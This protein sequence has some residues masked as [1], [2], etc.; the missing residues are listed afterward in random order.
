MFNQL[1]SRPKKN[2]KEN[3]SAVTLRSGK[4]YDPPIILKPKIV[5]P[6]PQDDNPGDEIEAPK[7]N[8]LVPPKPTFSTPPPFPRRL[9]KTKKEE[10]D[11][12]ILETFC[13]VE[14]NIP[15]LDAI[16]KVP[17]YAKSN[18]YPR[19]V[20]EDVLVQVN[21][22]VFP[23][24]FYVLNME[25]DSILCSTPILL[26]RPFMKTARAKID[27]HKGTL[28]M[29][30]DGKTIR[31]NIFSAMSEKFSN[32]MVD[33]IT[34]LNNDFNK[35]YKKVAY[36]EL[37][38]LTDK[39]QPSIVQ[40][41][42]IELKTMPNHLKYAYLGE[43]ETLPVMIAKELD[44]V[45]EEKFIRVLRAHRTAITWSITNIKGISPTTCIRIL[46]K[47]GAKPTRDAQRRLNP[48][49][50]EVVNK[51]ILK[52]FGV[53]IIYP[54]SYSKWVSH[55]QVVPKIFGI[56]IVKNEDNELVPTRMQ[57]GWQVCIDYRKLNAATRKDHFTLPFID[58]MLERLAGHPYYCFHDGYSNNMSPPSQISD[59]CS[60]LS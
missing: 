44:Q 32:E 39:L 12:E 57:I 25:D 54:I 36:V 38:F 8:N 59:P 52:L 6:E 19:G 11:K 2:P 45:Q 46:L 24:D 27:V 40:A 42:I 22:L 33:V 31:F 18:A 30:F 7:P 56:T 43:N 17:R 49:M 29:E 51:E 53:G 21:E 37:P 16:K 23:V 5:P 60:F 9:K 50:M 14:V 48:L 28:T 4:Q 35:I 41:P 26:G 20:I 1:P 34:T 55:V 58:Q 10:V 3:A 15:L 47:E 13:K